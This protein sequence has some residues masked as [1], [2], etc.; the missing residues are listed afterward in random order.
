MTP[1]TD[2]LKNDEF[3]WSKSA[4]ETFQEIK[5]KMIEAPVLRLSDFSKVFKVACDASRIGIGG[6]LSQEDHAV[7]YFSEN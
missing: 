2:C 7:T 6:V 1:I 5:Q 3:S 4:T